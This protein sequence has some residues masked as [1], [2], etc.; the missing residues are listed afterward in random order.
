MKPKLTDWLENN[1]I[2]GTLVFL[3]A[4]LILLVT[5]GDYGLAW[6]EPFNFVPALSAWNWFKILISHPSIALSPESIQRYWS[7]IA[8]HPSISKLIAAVSYGTFPPYFG[9]LFSYRLGAIVFFCVFLAVYYAVIQRMF[10]R[11]VAIFAAGA[12]FTMPRIFGQSHFATTDSTM[13]IMSFYTVYAFVRGLDNWKWSIGFALIWGIALATKINA[14]FLPIPLVIWAFCYHRE[15]WGTNIFGLF[16]ISPLVFVLCWPW[17]WRDPLTKIFGYL[18]FYTSHKFTSVYYFGT[19]YNLVVAPWHYPLVY[20][21]TVIPVVTLIMII[22]GVIPRFMK[23]RY[24]QTRRADALPMLFLWMGLFPILFQSLPGTPRYDGIRLFLSAFPFLAVL[25]GLGFSALL[26]KLKRMPVIQQKVSPALLSIGL[27]GILLLPSVYHLYDTHPYE[28]SYYNLLI[29]G[30][31]GAKQ[32]GMESTYWG[33]A[34]SPQTL[35]VLNDK[36][37]LNATVRFYSCSDD[38]VKWYRDHQYLRKDIQVLQTDDT[39]PDF[40]VLNC[41]QG[42]FGRREWMLYQQYVPIYSVKLHDVPLVNVYQI[43]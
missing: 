30:V 34:L 37:P 15:K 25:G 3:L 39:I 42:F 20:T 31:N 33:E 32:A 18:T 16:F 9:E 19:F 12:L 28:L 14:L 4:L 5:L 7:P 22:A 36:L 38:V 1:W 24:H 17:L 41:R 8:E 35:Y 2:T 11:W 40:A 6:D 23:L 27:C 26:E 29:G 43:K 10:N 13:M 21:L